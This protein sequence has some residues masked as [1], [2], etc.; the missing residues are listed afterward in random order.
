VARDIY[1]RYVD[2]KSYGTGDFEAFLLEELKAE[3]VRDQNKCRGVAKTAASKA[4]QTF[5]LEQRAYMRERLVQVAIAGKLTF[6]AA[7]LAGF[8]QPGAQSVVET[9]L[10]DD[11][12][13]DGVVEVPAVTG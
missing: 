8:A 12:D 13:S 9:I 2:S 11:S 4:N 10:I 3:G 1:L 5:I 6:S 7:S